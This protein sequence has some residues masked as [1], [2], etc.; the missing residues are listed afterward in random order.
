MPTGIK[1]FIV[2]GALL[3]ASLVVTSAA[4]SASGSSGMAMDQS[5]F[6]HEATV[7]AVKAE[8]QVMT[9]AS[10]KMKDPAGATHH[11]M[12]KFFDA[13]TDAPL[14]K[15]VGKIKIISPSRK[16]AVESLKDYNG[17]YAANF[18]FDEPGQ[19]GIICLAKI[20]DKKLLYK[21]W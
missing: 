2:L 5:A 15:A 9:L 4:L 21:F 6:K 14:E 20:E 7:Q 3:A 1:S 18:T 13:E 19:Y 8:F 12:V 17:I 10:M 16:E 11:V